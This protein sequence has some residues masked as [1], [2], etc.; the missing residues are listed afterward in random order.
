MLI[1]TVNKFS[2]PL[3]PRAS[4]SLGKTKSESQKVPLSSW[5]E[6]QRKNGEA[7]KMCTDIFFVQ[8]PLSLLQVS[9]TVDNDPL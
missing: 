8:Y 6:Q 1:R 2:L 7:S 3:S 9:L 4:D 5:T